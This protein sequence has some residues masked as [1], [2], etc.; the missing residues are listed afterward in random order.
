MSEFKFAGTNRPVFFDFESL[1]TD[2]DAVVVSLGLVVAD[3]NDRE[4]MTFDSL[5]ESAIEI[6]LDVESQKQ[7]RYIDQDTVEWWKKQSREA[8]KILIPSEH[9]VELEE[10][11]Y[12]L[13]HYFTGFEDFNKNKE[14]WISRRAFDACLVKHIC[15][16]TLGMKEYVPFWNWRDV[17][18]LIHGISYLQRGTFDVP[19]ELLPDNVTVHD[20]RTDVVLDCLRIKYI[21]DQLE[22]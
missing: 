16:R 3:F 19:K 12:L 15:S 8:Q 5:Y 9:D 22:N 20:A 17:V 21:L 7:T 4:L 13:D 18:S 11:F 14:N 10:M 2:S 1:G 6:K